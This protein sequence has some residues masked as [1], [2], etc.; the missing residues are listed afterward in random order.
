VAVAGPVDLVC[1]HGQT[2]YHWVEAGR[3][4]GSL[5]IGQAALIAAAVKAP[6]VSDVR[7]AD[8]A[9]GGQGAP[10]VAMLDSLLLGDSGRTAALNLGGIAN[11]TVVDDGRC[12]GAYDIGPA[13]ALIDAV[14][15]ASGDLACDLDGLLAGTGTVHHGLLEELLGDPYYLRRPPKTTG[16]ERFNLSRL[17]SA[18][19]SS[20]TVG[21]AWEDL[22][23]TVTELTARVV[24]REI[25]RWGIG[26]VYVSG[27]G[28]HNPVLMAAIREQAGHVG[29]VS[30]AELGVDPDAKEALA[31]ALIGWLTAH[32]L[33][34]NVPAAT[35]ATAETILGVMGPATCRPCLAAPMRRP[36][37]LV[38]A[39]LP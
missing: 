16:R 19:E 12:L 33:P 35:G 11:L 7:A 39:S 34:G 36:S 15:E 31:F 27:G 30:T 28:L 5:Q 38:M 32:G 21:L 20:Q 26:R 8:I 1:S 22:A 14:A 29:V 23:A 6:A 4:Q 2:V 17:R 24:S 9:V 37:R 13:N 25:V 18:Q 3:V 10:L